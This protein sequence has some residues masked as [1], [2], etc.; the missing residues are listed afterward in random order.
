MATPYEQNKVLL[1]NK[2]AM[3]MV[4]EYSKRKDYL[5]LMMFLKGF[6]GEYK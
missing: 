2:D 5:G 1:R 4:K 3:K 6:F